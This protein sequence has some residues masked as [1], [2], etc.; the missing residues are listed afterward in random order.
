MSKIFYVPGVIYGKETREDA[1]K[2]WAAIEAHNRK[3][4][5]EDYRN[6]LPMTGVREWAAKRG[7]INL[8]DERT[9]RDE[10]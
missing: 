9:R 8:N 7:L 1:E 3:A 6:S 4:D 2:R 5:A 10:K